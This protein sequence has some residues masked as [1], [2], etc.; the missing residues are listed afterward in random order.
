MPGLMYRR[1]KTVPVVSA[2]LA[3]QR[4]ARADDTH[5]AAQHVPELRKLVEEKLAEH[6]ADT[7]DARVFAAA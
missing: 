2:D 4:R 3:G 1:R 6:G 7:R 5:V